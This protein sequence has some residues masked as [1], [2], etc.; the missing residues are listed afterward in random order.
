MQSVRPQELRQRLDQGVPL[1]ILDVRTPVEYRQSHIPG[2]LL[3]PLDTLDPRHILALRREPV[4]APIYLLCR[5]GKR[6]AL[7]AEKFARAGFRN[8]LVIEGGIAACQKVGWPLEHDRRVVSL[9]RQVRIA[10]GLL[11]LAGIL[12][13]W[14]VH[15]A[16]YLISGFVGAGLVFAGV[17]DTCGMAMLLARMPW[18]RQSP[19]SGGSR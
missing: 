6:A 11:V 2:S 19:K 17:T 18:N 12:V 9:E 13:G 10:A 7:A 4:D 5:S 16:G 15:P 3:T 1:E 14:F 8:A